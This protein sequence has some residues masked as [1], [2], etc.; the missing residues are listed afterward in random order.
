LSA[1]APASPQGRKLGPWL[2]AILVAGNMIGSGIYGLPATL[3][4]VGG[5]SLL[6]WIA[7]TIG[8]LAAAGVFANLGRVSRSLDGV[9]GYAEEGLGRFWGFA[10]ALIYWMGLWVGVV[11]IAVVL[12]GY[13]AVF[14]PAFDTPV[15]RGLGTAGA[16]WLLTL[17]NLISAKAVAR[18]GGLTL[19]VGLIPVLAIATAGWFWFDPGILAASWNVS[20]QSDL[21]AAQSAMV[22]AFWAYTGLE[23]AAVAAAV[24]R[25]PE[26]NVP[27]ATL[28]G[29]GLAAIVYLSA[30]TVITGLAPAA[31]FAKSSAP[32]AL[33]F[34]RIAGPTAGKIVA[35]CA[36]LKVAGTLGGWILLTAETARAGADVHLFPGR[37]APAQRD[38]APRRILIGMAVVMSAVALATISPTF[39]KQFGALVDVAT[40][41]SI[42]PYVICAL[43]LLRLARA[44]PGPRAR[45]AARIGA[46]IAAAVTAWTIATAT[47]LTLW[48]TL[49]LVAITVMLWFVR[50][51]RARALAG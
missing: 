49:A 33:A 48:L 37:L 39:G 43:A 1:T 46:L 2:A 7:A 26:R 15:G 51:R 24:V 11:G 36:L 21:V 40:V 10:T 19:L 35:V 23:S 42:L 12:P 3:G 14:F 13:L 22:S 32:L 50:G 41:W 38:A 44:L 16:I 25:D 47:L 6:G 29:T 34:S 4:A 30:S 18:L 28:V 31:Q 8:A 27:F 5:V 9:V 45:L 17:V 20:G